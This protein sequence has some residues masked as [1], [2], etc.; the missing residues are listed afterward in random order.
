[1]VILIMSYWILGFEVMN[2]SLKWVIGDWSV[3]KFLCVCIYDVWFGKIMMSLEI[4]NVVICVIVW[5]GN[6]E[7]GLCIWSSM[8][9]NS[10]GWKY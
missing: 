6:Y 8:M 2:F 5:I 9:M 1:M 7:G 3:K 4:Y 10:V